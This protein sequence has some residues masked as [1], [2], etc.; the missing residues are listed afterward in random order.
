MHNTFKKVLGLALVGILC[1][2]TLV[3]C[4]N[5]STSANSNEKSK[6]TVKLGYVN[7]AEGI[8]MTNLAKAVLE[9]KM[10]YDVKMTMGDAGIIYTSLADGDND[11][12]LDAWLPIT[13]KDYLER[14]KDDIENLGTNFKSARIGLVVPKYMNI[15]SIEELNNIKDKIDGKI[16]GIDPGAGIMKATDKAIKE[17]GLDLE[18]LEGSGATMTAMLK[19]AIDSKKNIVVTGW[20]PHWKFARWE[21]K[22]L[23]DP[24]KVYGEVEHIDTIARKGFEKDMPD[25]ANFLKNFQMTDEELGSLM[26][27]I[28][29]SDKDAL[30]V[31]KEWMNKHEE[32][33]NSWIPK[34]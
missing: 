17:Y 25:V 29:D 33:V 12:F 13:H 9:E 2:F 3:G 20:N 31:A 27:E 22:F 1:I 8:A 21:L 18:I 7:W 16:I 19:E 15:N 24:K 14:Y 4:G 34:K 5:K 10:G 11:A 32:L 26:G 23:E 6:G 28:A 30:E